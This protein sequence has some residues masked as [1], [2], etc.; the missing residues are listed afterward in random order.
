MEVVNSCQRGVHS[1][2]KL[3]RVVEASEFFELESVGHDEV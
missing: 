1:T 2:S 3:G